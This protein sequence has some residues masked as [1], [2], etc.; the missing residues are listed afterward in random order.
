MSRLN[1]VSDILNNS[2]VYDKIAEAIGIEIDEDSLIF[3]E[4]EEYIVEQF[5]E[6]ESNRPLPTCSFCN[7][8]IDEDSRYCSYE[9]SKADNQERV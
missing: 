4:I 7:N 3:R 6:M 5:D 8:D 1:K 9:C 2:K